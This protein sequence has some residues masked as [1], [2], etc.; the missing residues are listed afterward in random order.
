[1][2][3]NTLHI[4]SNLVGLVGLAL[5]FLCR[6]KQRRDKLLL[7]A[8]VLMALSSLLM[9]IYNKQLG[10]YQV[11]SFYY[12]SE[13]L[14]A[15]LMLPDLVELLAWA[16][17]AILVWSVLSGKAEKFQNLWFLPMVLRIAKLPLYILAHLYYSTFSSWYPTRISTPDILWTA[18]IAFALYHMASWLIWPAGRP[19][20]E[21]REAFSGDGYCGIIKHL[22]LSTFTFGIWQLMWLHR[23]TRYLNQV[24]GHERMKPSTQVIAGLFVPFY[25]TYWTYKNA[26]KLDDLS[27]QY[28]YTFKLTL[29]CLALK[30]LSPLN[31]ILPSMVMQERINTIAMCKAGAIS[32]PVPM[33]DNP[34]QLPEL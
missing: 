14:S 12:T 27:R 4:L 34:D 15:A 8:P 20:D 13:K 9:L 18:V 24:E 5:L 6:C 17:L 3:T 11:G 31:I 19:Q 30:V 10:L 2:V 25:L 29:P 28:G 33:E 26:M 1:M 32:A 23:T 16:A 21:G 7:A 22:L